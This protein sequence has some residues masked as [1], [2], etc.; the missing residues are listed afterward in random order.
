V[1][2]FLFYFKGFIMNFRLVSLVASIALLSGC[3]SIIKGT[4]DTITINSIERGTTL[5]VDGAACG[6]DTASVSLK[7]GKTYSLRAEKEG[8]E[9]TTSTTT[10]SFDPTSLLGILIDFG[11][12]SIPVDMISGAA[13][14]IE[15]TTYT[16]TPVCSKKT[17]VVSPKAS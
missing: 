6:L 7:K 14:K 10:E 5:Y 2:V 3:S 16:L 4:N 8:C 15:P 12:I 17:N 13:W 11:L 9:S 1:G